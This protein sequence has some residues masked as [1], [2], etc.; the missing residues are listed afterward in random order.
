MTATASL[1]PQIVRPREVVR[2]RQ[3]FVNRDLRLDRID[4]IG[5]DMDYTLAVY[6]KRRS[7]E[8]AF[9][10]TLSR[11]VSVHGYPAVIQSVSYDPTF[12]IRGL[13]IDKETGNILKAD[14]FNHVG[15]CYH[16]RKLIDKDT[17]RKTYRQ[18]RI[19][20]G[21]DRY[22]WIDTLFALPEACLYAG[23]VEQLEARD[24]KVDFL[25]LYDDIRFAIDSV[26]RDGTLKAELQKDLAKY[27]DKNDELAPM[28]HKLRSAGKKLFIA[29]NSY[30]E[31]T[32]AVMSF[33][34]DG[35]MPEYPTW[36][37]YFDYIHVGTQKP[38][39]FD[40][41]APFL[42][43]DA[44]G[45]VIGETRQLVRGRRY[46]G[47][48]LRDLEASIGISGDRVLYVGDHIYGD[49]VTSKKHSTWRTCLVIEELEDEIEHVRKSQPHYRRIHELDVLRVQLDA[50]VN[51]S[52][53]HLAALEREPMVSLDAVK[54]E[55][56]QLEQIRRELK[57]AIS[58]LRTL[59]AAVENTFNPYWG[60]AFK[61]GT[62]N[63]RFG[64]QVESFACIYTSRVTN[65]LY[66]SPLQYFR[67]PREFMPHELGHE[68]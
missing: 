13:V 3:I 5:F 35:A 27:I 50:D 57:S 59:D 37:S 60:F 54:R 4:L 21:S 46:Q 61:E 28:L 25:K 55:K 51:M 20:F 16:G 41:D 62:E 30:W 42:E 8:L 45:Q 68:D 53:M 11:L 15:R 19:R 26:H 14:R 18:E 10:M 40:E 43:L 12:V 49:I 24:T 22:A 48:N 44:N 67:S 58:E 38:G 2:E 1:Q 66:Y 52:K 65:L 39:F 23:I 36:E 17:L 63:S 31:Y 64:E 32:N 7:E 47:G 56:M 33:L 6:H 34:L 9:A 29:T